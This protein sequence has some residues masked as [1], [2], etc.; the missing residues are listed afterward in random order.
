MTILVQVE[1]RLKEAGRGWVRYLNGKFIV[2]ENTEISVDTEPGVGGGDITQDVINAADA[3]TTIADDDKLGFTDASADGI[4]KSITGLDLTAWIVAKLKALD[5]VTVN[6]SKDLLSGSG[7]VVTQAATGMRLNYLAATSLTDPNSGLWKMDELLTST[8]PATGTEV[9]L[10][11]DYL[12]RNGTDMSEF[13]SAWDSGGTISI[14]TAAATDTS[15]AVLSIV[16]VADQDPDTYYQITAIF[17]GGSTFVGGESCV[18]QYVPPTDVALPIN[19]ATSKASP[20]DN[21]LFGL[22]D[23]AASNVLKKLSWAN[24]KVAMHAYLQT[25]GYATIFGGNI[26]D[27]ATSLPVDGVNSVYALASMPVSG[28]AEIPAANDVTNGTV[29]ALHPDCLLGAASADIGGNKAGLLLRSV[30]SLNQWRPAADRALLFS[31]KF[32]TTASPTIT[33]TNTS[34][35]TSSK[36]PL[37][38]DLVIPAGLLYAGCKLVL[39]FRFRRN[40]SLAGL[41]NVMLQCWMGTNATQTNNSLIWQANINDTD[42]QD[43]FASPEIVFLTSTSVESTRN[44][45][46]GG[47]GL[48]QA[49]ITANTL[50]DVASAMNISWRTLTTL[51]GNNTIDFL[52]YEMWLVAQ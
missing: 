39:A 9:I 1:K 27:P 16:S 19:G 25:Q 35:A 2:G 20:V 21:D 36:F 41:G 43:M 24:I 15:F 44:L 28:V 49:V 7:V 38:A 47:A 40:V 37:P 6:A 10:M 32:G 22:V 13:M 46:R 48:S 30:E 29:I 3:K 17:I 26:I 52:E 31:K 50:I 4:L 45:S 33:M 34:Q 42:D 8:V 18:I 14:R 23:S 11:I 51:N 5:F 12:D